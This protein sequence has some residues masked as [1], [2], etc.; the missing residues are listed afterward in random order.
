MHR[1]VAPEEAPSNSLGLCTESDLPHWMVRNASSVMLIGT[2]ATNALGRQ[3]QR[4]RPSS[5]HSGQQRNASLGHSRRPATATARQRLPVPGSE[6]PAA[7]DAGARSSKYSQWSRPASASAPQSPSHR[8]KVSTARKFL[9]SDAPGRPVSREGGMLSR[10]STAQSEPRVSREGGMLSRPSTAQSRLGS[11]SRSNQDR[12]YGEK[13][14]TALNRTASAAE[15]GERMKKGYG[16]SLLIP[17]MLSA[18]DTQVRPTTPE[19]NCASSLTR[20]ST[21]PGGVHHPR[22][23]MRIGF[24]VNIFW[25]VLAT[26]R[27]SSPDEIIMRMSQHGDWL[28]EAEDLGVTRAADS[29]TV[30]K[31]GNDSGQERYEEMSLVK[32]AE[33]V[34]KKRPQSDHVVRRIGDGAGG[35]GVGLIVEAKREAR[36]ARRVLAEK[37]GIPSS[38]DSL[39]MSMHM[40]T[41]FNSMRPNEQR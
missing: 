4:E 15:H 30:I 28:A 13:S 36:V 32:Q 3:N 16:M 35:G 7:A 31:S 34:R 14:G 21:H 39:A 19:K 17:A 18:D 25:R 5:A 29:P 23:E 2:D 38:A 11:T 6:Q 22:E 10:P 27:V 33:A 8:G 37:M 1:C 9:T 12:N 24:I 20:V 40:W 26:Q 41:S